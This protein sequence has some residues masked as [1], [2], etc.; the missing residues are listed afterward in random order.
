M[1]T[2]SN[3]RRPARLID[4]AEASGVAVSTVSRVLNKDETLTL[5]PE[6]KQRV[7]DAAAET[8]YRANR[9][10]RGLRTNTTG[11]VAIVVPSLRNPVW[12]EIVN[13][14][15]ARAEQ[16]DYVVVLVELP[17]D[18]ID[19]QQLQD[20]MDQGRV[21]GFL[22]ASAIRCPAGVPHVYLNR[23]RSGSNR[24]VVM[25]ENH[26][27]APALDHL[28]RLGHRSIAP[29]DS[30]ADIDTA[31]RRRIA[32]QSLAVDI[33]VDV[34]IHAAAFNES[35]SYEQMRRIVEQAEPPTA[36]IVASLNQIIGAV[37]AI[38]HV[39]IHVPL[40]VSLVS[41]DEDEMLGYLEVLVTSLRMPLASLRMPLAEMGSVAF[42]ALIDQ[43]NGNPPRSVEIDNPID[44][45]VRSLTGPVRRARSPK[46]R[47]KGKP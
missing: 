4:V 8:R 46:T 16:Q 36:C 31:R 10:A 14:A 2:S 19:A 32:A 29:L 41:L 26:A 42:E 13:A 23:G 28:A 33:G 1:A 20:L 25:N 3:I 30:P 37:A 40:D 5:R 43:L 27:M 11:A 7:L 39:G 34:D 24:N 35:G 44:L 38:R 45:I 21:D 17:D 15:L 22:L 18:G 12:A 6:T 47:P 9:L